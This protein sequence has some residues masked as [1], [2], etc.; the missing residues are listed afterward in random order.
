MDAKLKKFEE[1]HGGREGDIGEGDG[2]PQ[3]EPDLLGDEEVQVSYCEEGNNLSA[4]YQE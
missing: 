1:K 2:D 3:T 4:G